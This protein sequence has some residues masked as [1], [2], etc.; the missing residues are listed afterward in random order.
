MFEDLRCILPEDELFIL[1]ATAALNFYYVCLKVIRIENG[2]LLCVSCKFLSY[3]STL[4]DL[5]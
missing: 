1:E 4:L 2:V 3:F 5:I